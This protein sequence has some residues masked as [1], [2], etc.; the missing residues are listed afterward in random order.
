M[1]TKQD[2][3]RERQER[4]ELKHQKA[5]QL[6]KESK[7]AEA[8]ELWSQAAKDEHIGAMVSFGTCLL[9]GMGM[10]GGKH[11]GS[12]VGFGFVLAT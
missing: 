11:N 1:S 12:K 2:V 9:N 10:P 7:F 8:R 3:I 4:S 5:L 6:V